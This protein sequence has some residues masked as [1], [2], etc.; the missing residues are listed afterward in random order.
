MGFVHGTGGYS[1]HKCRCDICTAAVNEYN[2]KRQAAIRAGTWQPRPKPPA[3]RVTCIGPD[4]IMAARYVSHT[5]CATHAQQKR[6]GKELTPTRRANRVKDGMKVCSACKQNLPLADYWQK[7]GGGPQ[8]RCKSCGT[9]YNRARR[10][11]ISV[12]EVERLAAMPCMTCDRV[13][14]GNRQ[15][16][17]HDHETGAVRGVLCRFCNASLTKHMTPTI[18]RRL[19]DYLEQ[20]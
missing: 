7:T 14:S 18:L 1:H 2:R 12:E 5:L 15:H 19:A 16:L 4:C 11:G 13:V 8:S 17:D 6:E 9:T 3:E 20:S 10:L